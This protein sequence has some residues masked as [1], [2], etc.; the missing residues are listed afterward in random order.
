MNDL[1]THAQPWTLYA[2]TA[3]VRPGGRVPFS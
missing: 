3:Y 1:N 2:M